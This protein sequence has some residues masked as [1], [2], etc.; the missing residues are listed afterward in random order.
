MGMATAVPIPTGQTHPGRLKGGTVV[1]AESPSS[2]WAVLAAA[3]P[4]EAT[5]SSPSPAATAPRAGQLMLV[6]SGAAWYW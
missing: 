5:T 6:G 3:L 2:I 1:G 4:L